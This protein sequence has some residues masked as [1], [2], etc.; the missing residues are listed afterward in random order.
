[1]ELLWLS[2]DLPLFALEEAV[3]QLV[4]EGRVLR[5]SAE[6]GSY[7][8]STGAES[9]QLSN[10]PLP[11]PA[12][13]PTSSPTPTYTVRHPGRRQRCGRHGRLWGCP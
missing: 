1:M 5:V 10:T 13:S 12:V 11:N 8:I 9:E 3:Q 4:A 6:F 2:A 7:R